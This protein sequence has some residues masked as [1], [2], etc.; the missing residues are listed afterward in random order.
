MEIRRFAHHHL[1][2]NRKIVLMMLMRISK[3]LLIIALACISISAIAQRSGLINSGELLKKGVE[4][5]DQGKYK[6]AIAVFSKISRSDTNYNQALHELSLSSY[7]DSNFH[8]S[9]K[10]A[11]EG[12]RRFPEHA[13]DWYG[14]MAT[15]YDDLEDRAKALDIYNK[16]LATDKANYLTL[17]NKGVTLTRMEKLNE[18]KEAFQQCVIINPYY[19]SAHYFLGY[20]ALQEGR[21][22]EAMM[23][24]AACLTISPGNRY[25]N[26]AIGALA[27]IGQMGDPITEKASKRKPSAN[28]DFDAVQEI[29]VNKLAFD[30][31]Y[32]LKVSIEDPLIRQLQ[33]LLEKLE[34]NPSDNGFWMQ[35]YVPFYNQVFSSDKFEPFVFHIL[36]E[37]D[38]KQVASYVKKNDKQ[39]D[40]LKDLA[41]E[42]FNAIRSTR[43][44]QLNKREPVKERYY[45]SSNKL[46]G[47]GEVK[48]V[49]K[50]S[51]LVG[52]WQFYHSNGQ[53]QSKGKF[54]D[55]QE[56]VGLWEYYHSNGQLKEQTGYLAGKAHGKSLSWF[57]NGLPAA[58]TEYKNGEVEGVYKEYYY[59][60]VLKKTETYRNGK[61]NGPARMYTFYA[62]PSYSVN[63][64]DDKENGE[65]VYYHYN[66]NVRSSAR[67]VAGEASGKYKEFYFGGQV[68]EEGSYE[69][70]QKAGVWKEYHENGKLSVESNYLED[71][72]DGEYK[73]YFENGKLQTRIPYRKGKVD[74]KMENYD[75]DGKL[76]S[77]SN[78]E[79]DRLREIKFY[80]KS[81]NVISSST[82]RNGAGNI[83]FFDPQGNK[84][85]DGS[86][87]KEGLQNGKGTYYYRS[88]KTSVI[89]EYKDG[90]LNGTR[91]E[92]HKNGQKSAEG[93][94]AQN[95]EDGYH[96]AYY[97]DGKVKD[98]GWI[99]EG[100]KQGEHITYNRT[101]TIYS[102]I[103]YLDD[104][105]QGYTEYYHGNGKID[106]E[107]RFNE[108]WIRDITQF[109]TTGKILTTA[110]FPKGTGD[111]EFKLYN[112]KTY[113]K[114]S[115]QNNYL[116]GEY[117]ILFPD[118]SLSAIQYYRIG[119]LDS[120]YKSFY[121][122][123]QLAVEGKYMHGNKQGEW[124]YYHE[125][126][127]LQYRETYVDGVL[128][129][130]VTL[131]NE[132]GSMDKEIEYKDNE[133]HGAY[134]LYGENN[135]LAVQYQYENGSFI[136]YTYEDKDGKLV[137]PVILKNSTGE[138]KSFYKN[139]NKSVELKIVDNEGQG[140]RKVYFSNGKTYVDVNRIDGL[141]HGVKK[142]YFPSGQPETEENYYY[143]ELH[144]TV[145]SYYP[146]GKL[147]SQE[148]YSNGE[149]HGECK[150]YS[151]TG[152]PETRTYFYG[153]M[154][155]VK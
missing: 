64:T 56:R 105:Q 104:E 1:S 120:I 91:T 73:S 139:G 142:V 152:K 88:G 83:S 100:K 37:M 22:P 45:Y 51:F 25:Y 118:G 54:D 60:G 96:T 32:K 137:P 36:S 78:Y 3:P 143:G 112:G 44:L 84:M 109:D 31:K 72:L 144:G 126:G 116:N 63:Y 107:Q 93:N 86:F 77:E 135:L 117:K 59:N 79:R 47:L 114:G 14:L 17:F 20:I 24:Y 148:N 140:S 7:N 101:G 66:G 68:K 6:D 23:S 115:Y 138:V 28:D 110:S 9:I 11:E 16:I 35:Y 119:S 39:I 52:P 49:G 74:G 10:Y 15:A 125:N 81:G 89:A 106:Y 55:N 94:F 18:A 146:N 98:E 132:E 26:R 151:T 43:Q 41:I 147:K 30:K 75:D 34:Y 134:R 121:Y 38:I 85:S 48:I 133:Y 2:L 29:I 97:E 53:V 95:V 122:G 131:Y 102:R 111:F 8:A 153:V 62:T 61:R 13:S 124:K 103:N 46:M 21:I 87:S 155:S 40:H 5:N 123:G 127:K 70:N 129:G 33:V 92:F 71:E 12:L 65:L 69:K 145:T 113:I 90:L 149:R 136:S 4:L 19:V 58:E 150:Y 82:S 67:Y 50:E 57:D 154:Q 141:E 130:K 76:A 27:E 42:Y 128:N 80:D 99:V 108:G